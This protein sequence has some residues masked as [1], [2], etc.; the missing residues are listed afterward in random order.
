MN[1]TRDEFG[2]RA[3]S[4]PAQ[5]M[6]TSVRTQLAAEDRKTLI[7]RLRFGRRSERDRIVDAAFTLRRVVGE[8]ARRS[9]NASADREP[10][11]ELMDRY[12]EDPAVR[13]ESVLIIATPAVL[14]G[15]RGPDLHAAWQ[16]RAT[17]PANQDTE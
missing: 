14:R 2:F 16:S 17:R 6:L 13:D 12:L 4:L 9:G 3:L 8:A 10:D 5:Q 1:D 15:L 7:N 11:L